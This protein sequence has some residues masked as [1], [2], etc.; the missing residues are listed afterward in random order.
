V[1]F[2]PVDEFVVFA[3]CFLKNIWHMRRLAA[4]V[5]CADCFLAGLSDA[6][7]AL[8]LGIQKILGSITF[9]STPS[10]HV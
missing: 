6:E 3:G 7:Y 4:Y 2:W 9:S 8:T 5:V 1:S 10:V